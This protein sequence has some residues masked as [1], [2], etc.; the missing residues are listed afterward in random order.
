MPVTVEK[1][2]GVA[3][4]RLQ[5]PPVNAISADIRSGLKKAATELRTAGDIDRVILT[6]DGRFFAAGADARE[7]DSA[8]FE[9]H[10]PDV[11]AAIENSPV[12]W[13]AAIDGAALGG[14]A[15]LAL[16]CRY[17]IAAPNATI[18]LPEVS[19]GVVPGA[20]GTQRLPR[21]IGLA[22]ALEI[23]PEGRVLISAEA[24]AAGFVDLIENDCLAAA[25]SIDPTLFSAREPL[26]RSPAPAA[27]EPAVA[28]A[29]ERAE[30]RKRNEIAPLKAID[31]VAASVDMPFAEALRRE[32]EAFLELRRS[33]QAKALRHIFFA[34]RQ[35]KAPDAISSAEPVDVRQAV[36][37]GGGNM[38]ASIAY[39]LDNAGIRTT[40]VETDAEAAERAAA[41][42]GKLVESAVRRGLTAPDEAEERKRRVAIVS[43]YGDIGSAD[44]AIEAA[45]EHIDVKKEIFARL[46]K[47]LPAQAIL[48]TNTSYLD[49][50]E[51]ASAVS[52]PGRV[53]G[54]H[55][56]SP[57]HIMKLLEIVRGDDSSDAALATGFSLAKR[58]RK[59]PVLSGVCDGFIGNRI[60][61]RYREAAD[62]LLMDGST[63]W[64][65]DEAMVEFGYPMGPYEA[66]DLSG[67]DIAYANRKRQA[68][69]RD[70]H[71]RYIPISDR[72]VE[73]G[74]LGRKT[75]VGWYRY[76]GGGGKVVDPLIEDLVREE[77]YFAKV[78][79]RDYSHDEVRSRLVCA[80]V[81]EA[82]NILDERI[83]RT[84][85]D[86]DLVLI[87]GYG[88]PRWRG[89]LMFHA[90]SVGVGEILGRI[91]DY[92]KEDPVVWKPSPLLE[93]L[94]ES[95]G[96]FADLQEA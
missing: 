90:D 48:A 89:G 39:A 84:A 11:V 15:E 63:P 81:N 67:L 4:V 18:G 70:P 85:A 13:I 75:S 45:F 56:F 53:V 82:A 3:I 32:R 57:A 27:D 34:E 60:L 64:D 33:D 46:E 12:P 30:T 93:R 86:I 31:L 42:V 59:I 5:N 50:D 78:T 65:I 35:A 61:A 94:A 22:G 54:L 36:V 87:H 43:D 69:T 2:G 47:A 44:I 68:P 1:Q 6:G 95:G 17:R 79:R 24:H 19:L 83:A 37:V 77:A 51:I 41:N 88:F 66:Q 28:K 72:M 16:G 20:G 62:T 74:R 76:P 71:R 29:R 21:L 9:P 25:M 49:I 80:M 55:F 26:S 52:D 92:E 58:L 8:P 40:I 96:R 38:G 7:F 73:E 91:R 14:G 23:I 10:L